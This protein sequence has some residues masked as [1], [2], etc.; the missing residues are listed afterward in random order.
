MKKKY[1]KIG[2][3]GDIAEE[4]AGRKRQVTLFTKKL[5]VGKLFNNLIKVMGIAFGTGYRD[6]EKA[7]SSLSFFSSSR[8]E[9]NDS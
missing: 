3:L 9:K 1:R 5:E 4:L 7:G 6:W 8:E 2:D